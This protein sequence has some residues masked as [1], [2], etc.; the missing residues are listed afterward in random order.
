M[1]YLT[2]DHVSYSYEGI[3][4]VVQDVEWKIPKGEFHCLVGKSGCGKSTLL[5]MVAG[6]LKPN[7]GEVYLAD[8]KVV[9]PSAETGYVFQ[10]PTLLEWKSVLENVLLP[11]SLKKKTS[12][13]DYDDAL[14]LLNIIGLKRYADTYPSNLSGGQQSRVAIARALIR[15]PTMLFLDEPFAALDAITREGLQE[16][17]LKICKTYQTTVLFITHDIAEAI[18][19][20]DRVAVMEK[21]KIIYNLKVDLKKPRTVEMRYKPYF[22]EMGLKLRKALKGGL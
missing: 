19:L 12:K 13:Q 8:Q 14:S 9:E 22:N 7:R 20:S 3:E 18:Y 16:D 21:G 5:K 17:L 11:I 4:N 10:S 2:V 1:S 6:L 15:K